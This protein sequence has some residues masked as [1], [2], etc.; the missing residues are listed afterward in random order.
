MCG[1]TGYY[2]TSSFKILTD[3]EYLKSLETNSNDSESDY[4]KYDSINLLNDYINKELTE[5]EEDSYCSINNILID[6]NIDSLKTN[7]LGLLDDYNI[8]I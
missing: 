4:K 5:H 2:G 6:T 7:N 8:D 1:Q 3:I